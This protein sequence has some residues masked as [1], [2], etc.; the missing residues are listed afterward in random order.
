MKVVFYTFVLIAFIYN[1]LT[2]E[3][4]DMLVK[5]YHGYES[6][7][8]I[9]NSFQRS[10]HN[11][12]RVISIG[13]SVEGRDLLAFQI[14]DNID[15]VEPGEPMFKYV[16]NIHGD[17]AIGREILIFLIY[18]LLS[19]YKKDERITKLI[20]ETN[21]FIMPSA[22]PDGFE[23]SSEGSCIMSPGRENANKVDLNRNFPDQFDVFNRK[24]MYED[25]EKET[26]ALMNWIMENKFVLSANLHG[27]AVVASYPYDD[28]IRHQ[29]QNYYSAAPDD[30][31]FKHLA[32][33]YANSH[34]TMAKKD[35]CGDH[36]K[37]G[38]TNGAMWYDVKGGMQDF[39][40][41]HSNCFEI[42]VELS[43][44]KYPPRK[45]LK[46]EWE[47]NRDSLL[48][49][50]AQVHIG[51]K[52]FVTDESD[53]NSINHDEGIV[54]NPIQ[55]AI[56]RVTGINYNVSTSHYGDYWRLL[57]P[58]SYEV[59][60][61]A[62]GFMPLTKMVKVVADHPTQ[63]NFTLSREVAS[64]LKSNDGQDL[65][66]KNQQEILERLVSQVN[67]LT[68]HEKRE[69]ILS[70]ADNPSPNIFKHHD[71]NDM[72]TLI[73]DVNHKCPSITSVYSIGQSVNGTNIHA[74]I[75]S[76][77]PTKH[78]T[79]EPEFK[80]V[81]NMHGDEILG[82]ELLLQL[83]VYLCDNYGKSDFITNLIDST[84]IHIVPTINPDGYKRSQRP[85][86]NMIDL[87]R[88]FPKILPKEQ[89]KN[90]KAVLYQRIQPETSAVIKMSKQFPFVLSANLHSGSVVV[91][92][93]Y[94][95]NADNKRVDT[96]SPDD[97]AFEMVSLA[98]SKANTKMY[99]GQATCAKPFKFN[100][101]IVNG[102]VWYVADGTMQDWN[103]FYTND[104]EVT[105]ELSC[106]K[107]VKENSL[108]THWND[109]KFSLLSYIGQVHK[110]IKGIIKD[111]STNLPINKATIEIK[112]IL[113]NVTSYLNGDYWRILTPGSYVI[114]IVHD[115][116]IPQER[117]VTVSD[118]EAAV[119]D[120]DLD[121]KGPNYKELLSDVVDAV[122]TNSY[123]LLIT[124]CL[125][126]T[127][128][129]MMLSIAIYHRRKINLR[130]STKG[131]TNNIGFHRY[132]ELLNNDDEE[133]GDRL[134]INS[135]LNPTKSKYSDAIDSA[136]RKKLLD[137]LSDDDEE[138]DYDKIFAR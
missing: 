131:L 37:N 80:Y 113:K 70:N 53:K 15:R 59:T 6:M 23:K 50:M 8:N 95:L 126:F 96:P 85:N 105:I 134:T 124:G 51:I 100:H 62:N 52:G 108:R 13:K 24:K 10:Y 121:L 93:P 58:G 64:N 107:L 120:F 27:G 114:R 101:G 90:N 32:T 130:K 137:N 106:D 26:I 4:E 125:L 56:I 33:T 16:A 61:Y 92:Y 54:G 67:L 2:D 43:C 116:Y 31:V 69:N 94:D 81:G 42:T 1:V 35:H 111:K 109:N 122:S 14:T 133:A 40:Y 88:N 76:D 29:L 7:K 104:L 11:I 25:R 48:N 74:I 78:E 30:K 91:N 87:N 41:I 129:I 38:I 20:D 112:G 82:R 136:D 36:F 99:N 127:F 110:G 123:S 49:Y 9:L 72:V 60:A 115:K 66:Q 45:E 83:M 39:N 128:A 102:A 73:K 138:H 55:N 79:G 97:A 71:Q 119:A 17:E 117:E 132:S 118:G 28:S 19:N 89:L 65:N 5:N 18:H 77:N 3:T 12:S 47:N 103:Y 21:I 86:A 46:K 135:D 57:M 44:C 63:L 75:F 98:Y 22:N 34:K 68:D 84:R